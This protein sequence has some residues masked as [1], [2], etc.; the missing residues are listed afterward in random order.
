LGQAGIKLQD[1][2]LL[3]LIGES[4]E[5]VQDTYRLAK[6]VAETCQVASIRGFHLILPTPGSPIWA[7]MMQ[8]PELRTKYGEDYKFNIE[9]LRRDYINHFCNL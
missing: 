2:Y 8:I 6:K 3:G 9:E 1:N 7:K 5:T 4:Q